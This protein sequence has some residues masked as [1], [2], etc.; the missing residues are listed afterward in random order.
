MNLVGMFGFLVEREYTM[1]LLLRLPK[2]VCTS[3]LI[4]REYEY[5]ASDKS[6][7]AIAR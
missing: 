7:G 4:L 6:L 1:P 5:T 2:Y 3:N